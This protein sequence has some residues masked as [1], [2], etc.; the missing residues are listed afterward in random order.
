MGK[1]HINLMF[2]YILV[3]CLSI[4]L[5]LSQANRLHIH[6]THDDHSMSS[7]HMIGAHPESTLH[8]SGVTNGHGEHQD[9]HSAITVDVSADKL[10]KKTSLLDPLILIQLL[11]LLFLS[12]PRPRSMHRPTLYKILFTSSYYLLQPPLRAPPIK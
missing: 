4:T 8:D 1:N 12:I 11:A 5:L 9:K 6:L 10:F 2:K 7:G 3:L